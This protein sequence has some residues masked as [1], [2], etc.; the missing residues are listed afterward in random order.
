MWILFSFEGRIPRWVYW[1]ASIGIGFVFYALELALIYFFGEEH[2][3]VTIGIMVLY[4]PMI[5]MSLAIQVK[6]WHDVDKSWRWVL[7]NFIPCIGG[8]WALIENGFFRG[9]MG[10]NDYGPE[11][12]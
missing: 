8:L 4:P 3:A 1:T 2:T 5:W 7:I 11:P 9:T 12:M 6:R 10:P